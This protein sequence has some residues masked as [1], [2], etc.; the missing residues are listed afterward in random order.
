MQVI[1][2]KCNKHGTLGINKSTSNGHAYKYY[3]VQ[4]YN[5]ETKKRSWCYIGAEKS[6]PEQYKNVIHK[7]QGLYTN[8]AQTSRISENLNLALINQNND[9]S[10][11]GCR[12]AWSRLRDSGSRDS[13]PNPGSPTNNQVLFVTEK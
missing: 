13:G 11:R 8:Y 1:C 6:L 9:E 7:E 4:H 2:I 3:C 12:L 10:K 5:P